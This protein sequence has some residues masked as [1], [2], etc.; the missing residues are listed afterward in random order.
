MS[1]VRCKH[2]KSKITKAWHVEQLKC[3]HTNFFLYMGTQSVHIEKKKR[4]TKHL[5]VGWPNLRE[6]WELRHLPLIEFKQFPFLLTFKLCESC[7]YSH[8]N[9]IIQVS[10]HY[11][12]AQF[13]MCICVSPKKLKSSTVTSFIL[14]YQWCLSVFLPIIADT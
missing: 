2:K 11:L 6:A 8:L 3:G 12:F 10:W 14:V 1:L 13:R 7:N 4:I 9:L 5:G